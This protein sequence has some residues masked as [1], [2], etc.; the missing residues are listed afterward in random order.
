MNA[1]FTDE[2]GSF[3]ADHRKTKKLAFSKR[4][5]QLKDKANG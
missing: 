1:D 2:R 5:G 4:C 3:S